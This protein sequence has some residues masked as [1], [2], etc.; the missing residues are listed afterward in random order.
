MFYGTLDAQGSGG[1]GPPTINVAD[2]VFFNP[3]PTM[4]EPVQFLTNNSTTANVTVNGLLYVTLRNASIQT[5]GGAAPLYATATSSSSQV[6][7]FFWDSS[8]MNPG[9]GAIVNVDST[10]QIAFNLFSNSILYTGA[11]A[12]TGRSTLPTMI[13]AKCKLKAASRGRSTPHY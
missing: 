12:G 6:Q 13:P 10:S 5:S 1:E 11:I 9:A 7:F 8:N 3:P 2:D 4:F